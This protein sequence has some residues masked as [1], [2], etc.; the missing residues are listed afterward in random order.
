[1]AGRRGRPLEAAAPLRAVAD[2]L[3]E[4]SP[5]AVYHWLLR[6]SRMANPDPSVHTQSRFGRRLGYDGTFVSHVEAG[7]RRLPVDLC[8]RWFELV[9]LDRQAVERYV[10]SARAY[11]RRRVDWPLFPEPC[12]ADTAMGLLDDALNGARLTPRQW[13]IACEA[14]A[15]LPMPKEVRKFCRLAADAMAYNAYGDHLMIVGALIELP[16]PVVVEAVRESI[17]AAPPRGYHPLDVLGA[18]D[19]A[20]SGPVL[21]DYLRR[22][23]DPWMERCVAETT[24][25]LVERGEI[26]TLG[27][28]PSELQRSLIDSLPHASSW[29]VRIERANLASALGPMP[30]PLRRRL[31]TDPDLDV[32]LIVGTRPDEPARLAVRRLHQEAVLPTL[33]HMYGSATEDPLAG[34]LVEQMMLGRTRQQRVQAAHAL[35]LSP[36]RDRCADVLIDL[37]KSPM[38]EIRRAV[39]QALMPFPASERIAS[40]LTLLASSDASPDVRGRAVWSLM[41][42]QRQFV[43]C[44]VLDTLIA[45]IDA[46]VRRC[47]VDLAFAVGYQQ[48]V[49]RA[50]HDHDQSVAENAALL[51]GKLGVPVTIEP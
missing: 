8:D 15:I 7:R 22:T 4:V 9:G 19:G 13:A 10:T 28:D 32:R 29:T 37:T 1:M 40:V 26:T 23:P 47:A 24:R 14:A 44:D 3:I 42:D 16:E 35:A 31:S 33:D 49:H 46:Q 12:R 2:G 48:G 41:R 39:A 17:D 6:T 20:Y 30:E 21:R 50:T 51:L 36:Y 25:R 38:V 18:L 27:V 43:T 45:D 5:T 34:T 11:F